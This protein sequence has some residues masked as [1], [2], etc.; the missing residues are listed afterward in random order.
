MGEKSFMADEVTQLPFSSQK[1]P[2]SPEGSPSIATPTP[3]ERETNIMT[4]DSRR[5]YVKARLKK[6]LLGGDASVPRVPRS[7]GTPSKRCNKPLVLST[8]EQESLDGILDSLLGG[9]FFTIK[10]VLESKSFRETKEDQDDTVASLEAEVAELKKPLDMVAGVD[11]V[12][13]GSSE[14]WEEVSIVIGREREREGVR[15]GPSQ[16]PS[17]A[18]GCDS[19]GAGGS[20]QAAAVVRGGGLR[21][22]DRRICAG[23]DG[24]GDLQVPRPHHVPRRPPPHPPRA[25]PRR[26][27]EMMRATQKLS[28]TIRSLKKREAAGGK[29]LSG[30][31]F[32]IQ[33]LDRGRK[34]GRKCI[35][36]PNGL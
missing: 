1:D 10:E 14:K 20:S 25:R 33:T 19:G 36:E 34:K 26:S 4:Q 24:G 6:T 21:W 29:G 12:G 22:Q 8:T 13:G 7:W 17:S 30:K 28:R 32:S 15:E 18:G 9:N 35:R 16:S 5:L 11:N 3:V 2:P 23:Q 31:L 27:I